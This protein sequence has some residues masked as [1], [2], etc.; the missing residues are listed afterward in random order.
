MYRGFI[1][2]VGGVVEN[3]AGGLTVFA[4]ASSAHLVPGGSVAVAGV[5]LS[6]REVA[7]GCFTAGV[8]S[9]T[10]RRS[11]L[12]ALTAGA[13]VNVEL[14]IR[15]G[16]AIEGH[17]VQGHVDAIGRV[18]HVEDEPV[19]RRVWIRPP[20]RLLEA[21]VAKGSVAVD[22]VSLTV[23]EVVRERFSVALVPTTLEHTTLGALAEGARVNLESDLIDKLARRYEGRADAALRRAVAALPWVGHLSG[24]LGVDKAVAQIAAGGCVVVWDPEREA[25]GDVIAAG[26]ALRPETMTFIL[27][28]AC[29]HPTVPCDRARLERLE[30]PPMAGA[31]D[32]QGTA[33]HVSVD[34]AAARGT[35]VSAEERSATIRRLAHEAARPGD[36]V[37]P[38]H[39]FP[40]GAR[41][42]GLRER[43]GHTEATVEL[44]RAAKLPTVGV[45]CEVMARDGHMAGPAEL[46][47]FALEWQLPL[48][49]I[50]DLKTWL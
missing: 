47:R 36:F 43:P 37:R 25:E 10:V 46:E 40:L 24:R 1:G 8:S 35:G 29:S 23:A 34:L 3:G 44:C 18:L 45:C 6:A 9:E 41:P 39:V 14:P 5:C 38:G 30:I 21:L 4:P 50:A 20:E 11:T 15:A 49:E 17:L 22:G 27:T 31:G 13:S 26:A 33:M 48:I 32:H 12:G 28:Q 19:G 7:G 42:G 16:D 2:E